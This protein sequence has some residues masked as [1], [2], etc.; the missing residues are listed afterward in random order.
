MTQ[1]RKGQDFANN[2]GSG[3]GGGE[4]GKIIWKIKAGKLNRQNKNI[5]LL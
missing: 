1:K 3:G 4:S 5:Y 2:K